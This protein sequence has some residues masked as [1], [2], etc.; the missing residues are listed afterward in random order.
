MVQGPKRKLAPKDDNKAQAYY[1]A[2]LE[3]R[4]R[5]SK[6]GKNYKWIALSNTT[7]GALMSAI[8]GT[9][10]I[11]SLPA[12]FTGLGINP[13]IPSNI[14][15]LLWLLLGYMLVSGVIVVTIGRLSDMFG[16]V[17]LYN[18]GFAIF[19]AGS[20]CL[21]ISSLYI[22]GVNGALSLIILRLVQ[23]VGGGF[24]FANSVAILT[25]AFPSNER[26]KAIGFNQIAGIGGGI[27]GLIL[28]GIL[29]S[30]DWHLI[31]LVNV[32]IGI[33]G[34]VWAYLALHELAT[35]KKGQKFDVVGN[36]S[37]TIGLTLILLAL[38][39]G[40][41]PYGGNTMGWKSPYVIAGIVAGVLMLFVFAFVELRVKFPMFKLTLF[42]IRAFAL[43]NLSLLLAGIARGG[44]QFMIIIWLQGI[45]LPLH[46]VEFS[47]TPFRAAILILP[48]LF[49]FLIFG[50]ISGYLSDKYGARLFSTLG[51]VINGAGFL[52]LAFVPANFTYLYFAIIIFVIG[53]GQGLFAA[54]NTTAIMNSVPPEERGGASGMRA[55]FTNISLIFSIAI[56]FTLLVVGLNVHLA[57]ALYKGLI[58]QQ[59]PKTEALR[60][61]TLPPT[62]ALFAGL[63]GYNPMKSLIN[64]TILASLPA[65]NRSY[66]IGKIFFPTLISLPFHDGLAIVLYTGAIMSFIAAI[67]SALRGKRFV[68]GEARSN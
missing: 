4:K 49:G 35:I 7:L 68:Y 13:L 20:I 43:G 9:I 31:F 14:A 54:P 22:T 41:L 16:R 18:I 53:V 27:L 15:L 28:G 5:E 30:F 37:F 1:E 29:S 52:I 46:G 39:Y 25:D 8:N 26:G 38:T 40:L 32:P 66:V 61:S 19:T 21:Y 47:Q 3:E 12:V 36:V 6:Y 45:W 51:M 65:A 62:S 23:A 67:A 2:D 44:L 24:L 56:F 48:L 59:I 34:T 60:V 57:P 17:K 63:L 58:A 11:I 55:T 10:L 64:P 42:K 50:P 33:I